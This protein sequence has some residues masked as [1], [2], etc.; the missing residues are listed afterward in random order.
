MLINQYVIAARPQNPGFNGDYETITVSNH[1]HD[2]LA[3][4]IESFKESFI[5]DLWLVRKLAS[6]VTSGGFRILRFDSHSYVETSEPGS[7]LVRTK[8]SHFLTVI[9]RG[10]DALVASGSI[11]EELA[12]ALKDEARRRV[13]AGEFFGQVTYA[14][15]IAQKPA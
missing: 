15:L 14:S 1:P 2:P 10:A 8:L 9:D 11:G 5:N 4:C 7:D 6:L 12:A 13:D 3:A